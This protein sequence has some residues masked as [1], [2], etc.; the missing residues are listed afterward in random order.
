M[1][2]ILQ[3]HKFDPTRL[4]SIA[5]MGSTE[6]VRQSIKSK[7]GVSILSRQA[8]GDDIE[9]GFLASVTIKGVLFKR[10]FYLIRRKNRQISPLCQ[11]FLD[12]LRRSDRIQE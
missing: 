10:S 1:E 3:Q 12:Y 2:T 5:E 9:H 6:A 8:V 7:I 11:A 4:S